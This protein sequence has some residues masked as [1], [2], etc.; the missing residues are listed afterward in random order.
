[1][2]YVDVHTHRKLKE[3]RGWYI[4]NLY[5]RFEQVQQPGLYSVGLHPWY[6]PVQWQ[7]AFDEVKKWSVH[8]HVL[9]LGECGL[10]KICDTDFVLQQQV[11]AQHIAWANTL[12]KPLIIHCVKAFEETL[13]ALKH[14]KVPAI[15]HGF[16]KSR[17]LAL[18]IIGAGHYLSFG[19]ALGQPRMQQLLQSIPL[20]RIFLETDDS[21]IGIQ[22]VYQMAAAAYNIDELSLSLQLRQNV[23]TVFNR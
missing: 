1:M 7:H 2:E 9:A 10:D 11:F 3:T 8:E 5:S 16:N 21:D 13:L 6:V 19:K 17:E 22:Q 18:Q 12:G 15:F 20:E 23:K 4:Q 14:S